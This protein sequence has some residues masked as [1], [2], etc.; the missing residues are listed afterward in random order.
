MPDMIPGLNS[1]I[2]YEKKIFHI[3]TEDS[4]RKYAHVISHL[5]L[6]GSILAS[7]KTGYEDILELDDEALKENVMTIM[8]KS[9]R[10]MIQKLTG[11]G[12]NTEAG[13]KEEPPG[14]K[15]KAAPPKKKS[16]PEEPA[17]AS[18]SL[19]LP[20]DTQV[21]AE[22]VSQLST[23][24]RVTES[25]MEE[26]IPSS[27][28]DTGST[29]ILQ[30]RSPEEAAMRLNELFHTMPESRSVSRQILSI[31]NRKAMEKARKRHATHAGE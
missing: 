25:E 23:P 21:V 15:E 31:L 29:R 5:F 10:K 8:R 11:G 3:Q 19:L 26:V 9:H 6:D 28:D 16:A 17:A 27:P 20:S 13:I 24:K 22:S 7:V 2:K 1:N 12:F 30:K 18:S 14:E 4:G